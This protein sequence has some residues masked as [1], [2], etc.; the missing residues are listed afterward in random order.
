MIHLAKNKLARNLIFAYLV[1]TSIFSALCIEYF[2]SYESL[3]TDKFINE[4]KS[5][6]GAKKEV[7][8]GYIENF[9]I[10][11]LEDLEKNIAHTDLV[12]FAAFRD[13]SNNYFFDGKSKPKLDNIS[14]MTFNEKIESQDEYLGSFEITFSTTSLEE[15]IFYSRLK[16]FLGWIIPFLTFSLLFGF[17]YIK[18]KKSEELKSKIQSILDNMKQGIFTFQDDLKIN[19]NHSKHLLDIFETDSLVSQNVI[20]VI[21]KDSDI[22]KNDIAQTKSALYSALG[23][24]IMWWNLNEHLFPKEIKIN[25]KNRQKYLEL[26]WEPIKNKEDIAVKIMIIVRDVTQLNLLQDKSNQ[27]K[28]KIDIIEK[29]V[30]SGVQKVKKYIDKTKEFLDQN[31]ML[32]ENSQGG[33]DIVS[34]LF[35]NMHTIKGN[36]RT[37]G[38]KKIVD[39]VHLAEQKYVNLREK[40]ID[41]NKNELLEDISG[42]EN[43]IEKLDFVLREYF[44]VNEVSQEL[45]HARAI[46]AI[47]KKFEDKGYD[48]KL[49]EEIKKYSESLNWVKLSDVISEEITP[50]EEISSTLNKGK[51]EVKIYDQGML[52]SIDSSPILKDIMIHLFRNSLDHGIEDIETRKEL[53]KSISGLINIEVRTCPTKVEIHYHDDGRGLNI[54]S[55]SAKLQSESSKNSDLSDLDIAN[56]IFRPGTSTAKQVTDISGRGVGMDA[57]KSFLKKKSGDIS[58]SFVGEK[59]NGYQPFKFVISFPISLSKNSIVT[60]NFEASA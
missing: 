27:Q 53:K 39:R 30:K 13:E 23:E 34:E 29:I 41:W 5:F 40:K 11:L 32:I 31:K 10:S 42:I 19:D 58:I 35:R 47:V 1:V 24:K 55:L 3:L 15:K 7:A 57:V 26:S 12:L 6:I 49:M 28:E 18:I 37:L 56:S 45:I 60:S 50:L 43:E 46:L 4:R 38:F 2:T 8:R 16:Y 52:F 20:D 25:V 51:P 33:D 22:S 21:F 48:S 14:S 17:I 44:S 36:I 54:D 9:D 59:K